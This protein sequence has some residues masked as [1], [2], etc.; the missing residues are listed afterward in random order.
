MGDKQ[1]SDP[2][3]HISVLNL[4]GLYIVITWKPGEVWPGIVNDLTKLNR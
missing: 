2:M 4:L 1:S 3:I